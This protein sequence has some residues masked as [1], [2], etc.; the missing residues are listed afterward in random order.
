[1]RL[2]PALIALQAAASL[3]AC[4]PAGVAPD[5]PTARATRAPKAEAPAAPGARDAGA[6]FPPPAGATSAPPPVLTGVPPAVVPPGTGIVANNGAALTGK[7]KAPA[8]LVSNNGG[9]LISDKGAGLIGNHSAGI[10]ANN[11]GSVVANNGGSVVA[12]NGAGYRLRDLP[13]QAPVAGI[14]VGLVD[15]DGALVRDVAGKPFLTTTGPDGSYAFPDAPADRPLFVLVDL[16]GGHGQLAAVAPATGAAARTVDLDLVSTLTTA[17]IYNQYVAWQP[18]RAAVLAK[19][20]APV[21]AETRAKAE[22]A[23]QAS[24]A[25]VPARLDPARV[26]TTVARMRLADGPFD[27]QLEAVKQLLVVAGQA[28]LGNGRPATEVQLSPMTALGTGPDGLVYMQSII[29]QRIW[30]LGRTGLLEAVAGSSTLDRGSLTGKP[31]ARA[32]LGQMWGFGFDENG[33]ILLTESSN[34]QRVSRLGPDGLVTELHRQATGT[35][36]AAWP[37]AGDEVLLLTGGKV[38]A[39]APGAPAREVFALPAAD[40]AKLGF[41]YG[42]AGDGTGAVLLRVADGVAYRLDPGAKTLVAVKEALRLPREPAFD[43]NGRLY[44][45]DPAARSI[46]LVAP[47]GATSPLGTLPA[48]PAGDAVLGPAQGGLLTMT[49]DGAVYLGGG[50]LLHRLKDGALTLVAGQAAGTGTGGSAGDLALAAPGGVLPEADGSVLVTDRIANRIWRVAPD[51]TVAPFA[52]TGAGTDAGDGGPALEA[53][54]QSPG[55]LAR[56]GAGNLY[57]IAPLYVNGNAIRRIDPAGVITSL[58][59]APADAT[60]SELAVTADGTLF[61]VIGANVLRIPA[62]TTSATVIHTEPPQAGGNP[63]LYS[64]ALDAAG[65]PHWAVNG[66]LYRWS[67]A[68]GAVLVKASASIPPTNAGG[69]AIDAR[70]RYYVASFVTNGIV[71]Y[72]PAADAFTPIAGPGAPLLAGTGPDDSLKTPGHLVFDANGDLIVADEGHKQVKRLRAADLPE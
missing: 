54:I 36:A 14:A 11:G 20:P 65:A 16:P 64:L 59:A 35:I 21:E 26:A 23:F 18:D 47:D 34:I 9:S 2:G 6:P 17:Y 71:R 25:A 8:G 62:G 40:A 56:D 28:D 33:R 53:G 38:L 3:A 58:M 44:D 41:V 66:R 69:L 13:E 22:Q 55:D 5:R 1:V 42:F 72:D 15:A 49:P 27:G 68:T 30:R 61:T 51:G 46:A 63:T 24:G 48:G 4:M 57:L 70:G 7:V 67:E 39:V 45:F 31:G 60:F 50:P 10:V 52:G 37:G 19:L 12:N 32:G 43:M 29:E